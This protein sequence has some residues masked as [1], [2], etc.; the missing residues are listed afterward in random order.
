VGKNRSKAGYSSL[1]EV[2]DGNPK[3]MYFGLILEEEIA[4]EISKLKGKSSTG[5]D[6]IPDF[7]VKAFI[8]YLNSPV[9]CIFSASLNQGVFPDLLKVAKIRP[10]YKNGNKQETN[11][12]RPISVLSIFSTIL[13][14]IVYNTLFSFTTKF[15]I[16]TANQYSFQKSKSTISTCQSF[17][18][19]LQET[20]DNRIPVVGIFFDL[21]KLLM[22]LTKKYYLEN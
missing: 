9:K 20:S 14:R 13:Q 18:G 15:K 1:Q 12:Y 17:V 19:K 8:T 22:L 2:V 11:N 4:T 16:L 10:F 21:T 6:G 7:L 3:S 5:C